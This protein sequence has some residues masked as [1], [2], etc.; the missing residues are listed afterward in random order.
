MNFDDY[1][2]L[3]T[4]NIST[5][6][7]AGALAGV[8][9]H[10]VMYPLDSVKVRF[11]YFHYSFYNLK[12]YSS[13]ICDVIKKKTKTNTLLFNTDI[14]CSNHACHVRKFEYFITYKISSYDNSDN[15]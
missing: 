13:I 3:P 4:T 2:S 1:E 15:K 12:P 10:C 5:N 14:L 9:E 6:M 7:S 11:T 8:L